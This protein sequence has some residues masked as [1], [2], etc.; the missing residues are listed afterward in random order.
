VCPVVLRSRQ[1][2]RRLRSVWESLGRSPR[3]VEL[4]LIFVF[5]VGVGSWILRRPRSMAVS[6]RVRSVPGLSSRM[7]LGTVYCSSLA[8]R[9]S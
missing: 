5:A 8:V 9:G 4:V 7:V 3:F 1:R 2:A 6:I